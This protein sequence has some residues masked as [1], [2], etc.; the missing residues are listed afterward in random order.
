MRTRNYLLDKQL[1]WLVYRKEH[2]LNCLESMAFQF[3]VL[4]FLIYTQIYQMPKVVISDT[5]ILILF[6]KIDE[7]NLLKKV[8][9]ELITTPEIAEEFGDELPKWI[10]IQEVSDKKYQKL[11]ETQVDAGEASAIALAVEFDNVILLLDDLRARKLAKS[12]KLNITGALGVIHKAKQMS[13]IKKIK[14]LID[15][16]LETDFRISDNIIDELLKLNNE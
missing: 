2:L 8:Y 11:L 9:T 7:F 13:I 10:K 6:Y 15:K 16:L 14:P 5:S 3:S 4:L 12:L 1:K